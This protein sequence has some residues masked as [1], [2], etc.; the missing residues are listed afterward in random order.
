MPSERLNQVLVFR[1]NPVFSQGLLCLGWTVALFAV[2]K[3][4]EHKKTPI[5]PFGTMGVL[6]QPIS[7]LKLFR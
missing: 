6:E 4:F 3:T 1:L 5:F 7:E 2:Q